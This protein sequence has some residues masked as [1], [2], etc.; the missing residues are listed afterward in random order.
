MPSRLAI[1]SRSWRQLLNP[2]GW[3]RTLTLAGLS[4]ERFYHFVCKSDVSTMALMDELGIGN[5][6]RW[7]ATPM[8]IFTGGRL[9]EWGTPF[10]LFRFNEIT[11]R[12]RLRYGLF[13]FISVRRNR[14]D[15]IETE[16][17]RSWITRWCGSEVYDR[18]WK[19]LFALKFYQYA[20]NVSA[21]W[22]RTSLWSPW[23]TS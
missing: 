14:W 19:P 3:R 23:P 2:A 17:P 6:L 21:A 1:P 4:I 16:S 13:A 9:H 7:K 20:D 10:A 15:A 22:I 8:G 5:Q 12:S 18:L 11:L